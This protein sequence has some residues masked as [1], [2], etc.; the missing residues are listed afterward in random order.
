MAI[1][2]VGKATKDWLVEQVDLLI[3][4]LDHEEWWFHRTTVSALAPVVSDERTYQKILP[5]LGKFFKTNHRFNL[6]GPMRWGNIPDSI[7]KAPEHV[8]QLAR[9][10]LK[11]AYAGFV[12]YQHES[13]RIVN[14]VNPTL[15][16]ALAESLVALPGGHDTLYQL[17]KELYPDQEL[18]FRKILLS[19]DPAHLSPELQKIVQQTVGDN[20]IP[21]YVQ[22]NRDVLLQEADS[23][24]V[25]RGGA[26]EGLTELYRTSGIEDYDWGDFGPVHSEMQWHY[27]SFNPPEKFLK[28][29]DRMGRYRDVSLPAGMEKWNAMDFDPAAARWPRG[30]APFAAA[31]G[32]L[33]TPAATSCEL[34]FCK[35]PDPVNTLWEND[36]LLLRGTF[37][38]PALEE[39]YRYRILHGGISH[40]GSGGGYRLYIN[41]KLFHEDRNAVDRRGG[42]TPKGRVIPKQWWSEFDDGQ[43]DLSVITFKKHHPRTKKYG[44]NISI[45]LQRMKVP[46]LDAE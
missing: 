26:M 24:D 45:F 6:S 9:E 10:S 13:A 28:G 40:V 34:S 2:T 15:R 16:D 38:I 22:K 39:G 11:E 1:E 44:G 42:A 31:D 21:E 46:P 5:A 7:K 36:V 30:R 33:A 20:L 12:D 17:G 37:N 23:Q 35:C 14:I 8:Q 18:P 41:G 25:A 19:A 3:P 43:V 4:F 27:H 29:D 32:E